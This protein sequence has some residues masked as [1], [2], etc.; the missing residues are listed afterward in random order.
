MLEYVRTKNLRS[1]KRALQNY[2]D[3]DMEGMLR[4]MQL[5]II[6]L[7][8]MALMAPLLIF[9]SGPS[10]EVTTTLKMSIGYLQ[11]FT[12]VFRTFYRRM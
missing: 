11:I 5:S 9:G 4:W 2:Y 1:M 12:P 10:I 3:R 7:M 6:I 8:V